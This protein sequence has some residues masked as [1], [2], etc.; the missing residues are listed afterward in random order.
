MT[1]FR[2]I[3]FGQLTVVR[4]GSALPPG[5]LQPRRL[6]LLAFLAS[7]GERPVS[8]DRLA[9][10]LWPDS[11]EEKSRR[12][13]AQALYA[14]RRDLG[15]ED[16][17]E[18]V[19]ELRLNP[20]HATSDLQDFER[21][22]GER[23]LER[24]DVLYAGAFLDGFQLS[25][26]PDF[27][28]WVETERATWAER[29]K[30][31]VEQLARDA[32]QR[33]DTGAA[34]KWWRKAL[35][36]DVH[37]AKLTIKVMRALARGGDRAGAIRQAEIY[38]KLVRIDLDLA[39]DPAVL[40]EAS[41]IRDTP[42]SMSVTAESPV[43]PGPGSN[44]HAG[45][46]S[47]L[48]SSPAPQAPALTP[49][50]H[51][52]PAAILS[53]PP[54]SPRS[55][56]VRRAIIVI[57]PVAIAVFL[58]ARNWRTGSDTLAS[59]SPTTANRVLVVPPRNN[60]GDTTLNL[61][62]AMVAEWIT[63]GLVQT[64]L[65][66]V[67]DSRT[68]LSAASP[69]LTDAALREF[70]AGAGVGTLVTGSVFRDDD[71]LR[72]NMSIVDATTGSLRHAIAPVKAAVTR[73]TSAL[74][75]LRQSVTGALAVLFDNRLHNWTATTS[76]P[77]TWLAYQEFLL[78]MNAF[79]ANYARSLAH[80]RRAVE[81][82]SSYWQARLWTGITSSNMRRY[83]EADSIYRSLDTQRLNPYDLA[84]LEYF[85][86]GFVEGNWEGS[87]KGARR[88][89]ELAPGAGHAL[90]A[91]G[92][93]A[94][95]TMRNQEAVTTLR[96][97]DIERGWG[98][99][100]ALRILNLMTRS[101][102]QRGDHEQELADAVRMRMVDES[103]GW[104][105]L[106]EV[107]ALAA[108]KRRD[109][110]NRRID[111]AMT[112]PATDTTWEV[113]APGDL[114]LTAGLEAAAHGDSATGRGYVARARTWFDE[115]PDGVRQTPAM[116]RLRARALYALREWRE[117]ATAYAELIAMDSTV[118]DH[119]AGAALVAAQEG[120]TVTARRTLE[121]ITADRRPYRF[122][123]NPLWGARIATVLGRRE[124]AVAL[125]RRALAEGFARIYLVHS[126]P[127]L[128]TLRGF[129]PFEELLRSRD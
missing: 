79:G 17:F 38:E 1:A 124:D 56:L 108:L 109:E 117:A 55:A 22:R 78:G 8:R 51:K 31:V 88:M 21:L 68:M 110:L 83:P 45:G 46:S 96:R 14:L 18:G 112:L 11:D 42:T 28:R 33:G 81:L 90:Y 92:T 16:V 122:G 74:E 41:T 35:A 102:H 126:D 30:Q 72:F 59:A 60:T 75:P 129:A 119:V 104:A 2:T 86:R 32:E 10:L 95:F 13:L 71:S 34:V 48:P 125:I 103:A 4:D 44:V 80:F 54:P 93:T 6:A 87:Y 89:V 70:T 84:T 99:A 5:V 76:Q 50:G 118:V 69:T 114:L 62:G 127:D 94:A 23:S 115:L 98:V 100:W 7:A 37:N 52:S 39:P 64:G 40:N 61:V 116:R 97:I 57:A 77:P 111:A 65:V 29:H 113:F 105:R 107:R 123:A 101:L 26:L 66:D 19:R 15:S 36:H 27:E 120:D 20:E 63:N 85:R 91:L 121:A 58:L 49:V 9:A 43:V 25:G 12:S 47:N 67:I 82:D 3:C 73:P 106:P 53:D 24:A 128:A